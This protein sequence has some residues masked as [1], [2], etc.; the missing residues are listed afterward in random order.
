MSLLWGAARPTVRARMV[1]VINAVS[2]EID[3]EKLSRCLH[4]IDQ[5]LVTQF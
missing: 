3:E 5:F 1:L 2:A 4:S